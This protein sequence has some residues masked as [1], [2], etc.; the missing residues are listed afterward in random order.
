M[1][2]ITC[3]AFFAIYAHLVEAAVTTANEQ[4]STQPQQKQTKF[5]EM[6]KNKEQNSLQGVLPKLAVTAKLHDLIMS[7]EY[8][9]RLIPEKDRK[10]KDVAI[11]LVKKRLEALEETR[12]KSNL[13]IME[14]IRRLQKKGMSDD[15]IKLAMLNILRE[16]GTK[17]NAFLAELADFESR[18]LKKNA[19]DEKKDA[20]KQNEIELLAD[21]AI[22]SLTIGDSSSEVKKPEQTTNA[23]QSVTPVDSNNGVK[24]PN[25]PNNNWSHIEDLPTDTLCR[26][27]GDGYIYVP[28]NIKDVAVFAN[29]SD[30]RLENP[31]DSIRQSNFPEKTEVIWAKSASE[32]KGEWQILIPLPPEDIHPDSK[33]GLTWTEPSIF[34]KMS[35]DD[36]ALSEKPSNITDKT[37][38]KDLSAL[39]DAEVKA[40]NK[41]TIFKMTA[42]QISAIFKKMSFLQISWLTSTNIDGVKLSEL[43]STLVAGLN[44]T[45]IKKLSAQQVK[46]IIKNMLSEQ[47]AL[48]DT[49][50]I[51]LSLEE[52][53]ELPVN[54]IQAFSS[55]IVKNKINMKNS[56]GQPAAGSQIKQAVSVENKILT[57]IFTKLSDY[58]LLSFTKEDLLSVG[59]IELQKRIHALKAIQLNEIFSQKAVCQKIEDADLG[60]ISP[61]NAIFIGDLSIKNLAE[62]GKLKSLKILTTEGF[63]SLQDLEEQ[64]NTSRAFY[65][66]NKNLCNLQDDLIADIPNKKFAL[67]I[68]EKKY[69]AK[70]DVEFRKERPLIYP[71]NISVGNKTLSEID[72]DKNITVNLT[73]AFYPLT[74][75]KKIGIVHFSPTL[76]DSRKSSY[77]EKGAV[78]VKLLDE[79]MT[80]LAAFETECRKETGGEKIADQIKRLPILKTNSAIYDQKVSLL[81]DFFVKNNLLIERKKAGGTITVLQLNKESYQELKATHAKWLET[82]NHQKQQL[83]LESLNKTIEDFPV[84]IKDFI[85][86]GNWR[87]PIIWSKENS[88]EKTTDTKRGISNLL[89]A[90]RDAYLNLM[91]QNQEMLSF[92]RKGTEEAISAANMQKS[93][94]S[95]KFDAKTSTTNAAS[96]KIEKEKTAL[97][98]QKKDP[99]DT[100]AKGNV[101]LNDPAKTAPNGK[102]NVNGAPQA[103]NLSQKTNSQETLKQL[104]IDRQFELI[105]KTVVTYQGTG[106]KLYQGL[107]QSADNSI[108]KLRAE[109]IDVIENDSRNISRENLTKINSF[110]EISTL[111]C[112]I[113]GEPTNVA[114][115][116]LDTRYE[117]KIA[118]IKKAL[119]ELKA[120]YLSLE[121]RLKWIY[122]IVYL[123]QHGTIIE[124][125]ININPDGELTPIGFD[126]YF[127]LAL[128]KMISE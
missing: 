2:K 16:I 28:K 61:H 115:I 121:D 59:I 45:I 7:N 100:S 20:S 34:V 104:N 56:K 15:Q 109:I 82:R 76:V 75:D 106:Y 52:I 87:F 36:Q 10:N 11:A 110:S 22:E 8:L 29:G 23:T 102:Q 116:I 5:M 14:N 91:C 86:K 43:S 62:C 95:P 98:N 96:S 89:R 90:K 111:P 103:S 123:A 119:D 114:K 81:K 79:T 97:E 50:Q 128:L 68:I 33:Y 9:S 40:I 126:E 54:I 77:K 88:P 74:D 58:Q 125:W 101:T 105:G 122:V 94:S 49:E 53:N 99:A 65:I 12:E 107:V 46:E 127:K 6:G 117:N 73:K 25:I 24:K 4:K 26:T 51:G 35:S 17:G 72:C 112:T 63:S 32:D 42:E 85:S 69:M 113:D 92:F 37:S 39:S 66:F 18:Y 41:K 19:A 83:K 55:E 124:Q 47:V 60:R 118:T 84:F 78:L 21:Q 44:S 13:L 31:K 70:F 48:L 1:N 27:Q 57:E 64:D 93:F 71:D 3:I 67:E 30:K 38:V 108:I 120:E 80:K